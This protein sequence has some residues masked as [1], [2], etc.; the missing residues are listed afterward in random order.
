MIVY[1]LSKS[2][3]SD[4]VMSFLVLLARKAMIVYAYYRKQLPVIFYLSFKTF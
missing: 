2:E 3:D 4:V 1:N